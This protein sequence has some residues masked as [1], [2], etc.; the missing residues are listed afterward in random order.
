MKKHIAKISVFLLC[1]SMLLS[2]LVSAVCATP[3]LEKDADYMAIQWEID[4]NGLYIFGNDVRY[5]YFAVNAR[6]YID[7]KTR[8]HFINTVVLDGEVCQVYGESANPHLVLVA[9]GRG[10]LKVYADLEGKKILNDFMTRK[11]CLYY[12]ETRNTPSMQVALDHDFISTLDVLYLNR[13]DMVEDVSLSLL[14]QS[15][16]LEIAE[17]D[18]TE[19]V[20]NQHGAI[21]RLSDGAYYYV[22][23]GR[24]D[25]GVYFDSLGNFL[26][27][28]DTTVPALLLDYQLCKTVDK[29]VENMTP[30]K[31]NNV[32]ESDIIL[33]KVDVNGN[34]LDD[35][36]DD[37][38]N[39]WKTRHI[40]AAIG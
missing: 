29:H 3:P 37:Y 16:V 9:T 7:Q 38:T 17:H 20:G 21:F 24:L 18:P 15:H 4:K 39:K 35:Y 2:I 5:D 33:G 36:V 23:M 27:D 26:Y 8:F 12:L 14:N 40:N 10:T 30:K 1:L 19:T 22:Y 34:R 32:Y 31:W 11:N 6:F 28:K 25:R 13:S